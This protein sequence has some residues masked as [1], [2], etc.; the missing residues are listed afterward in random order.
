M[1]NTFRNL[2]LGILFLSAQSSLAGSIQ[3]HSSSGESLV[4]V[5][6]TSEIS[7]SYNN[8]RGAEF[9]PLEDGP[10][11]EISSG[12][13]KMAYQDLR[14]ILGSFS[15]KWKASDCKIDAKWWLS[16]CGNG[17]SFAPAKTSNS[18]IQPG[19]VSLSKLTESGA[20]GDQTMYRFRISFEK[21]ANTYFVPLYFHQQFCKVTGL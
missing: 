1:K 13:Y 5:S 14:E 10:V 8:S 21:D 16:S 7:L 17:G 2:I 11:R 12:F 15:L 19:G 3:C 4:F 9:T 6:N 20:S 18:S